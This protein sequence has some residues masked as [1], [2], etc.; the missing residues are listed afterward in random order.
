MPHLLATLAVTR[1]SMFRSFE[2]LGFE[3]VL[4]RPGKVHSAPLLSYTTHSAGIRKAGPGDLDAIVGLLRPLEDAGILVRR[5][6]E[7]LANLLQCCWTVAQRL[8][9]LMPDCLDFT[10]VER[11]TKVMGCALLLDLGK[12]E[13]GTHVAEVGRSLPANGRGCKCEWQ[14]MEMQMAEGANA[15]G[16]ERKCKWQRVQTHMAEDAYSNQTMAL[17]IAVVGHPLPAKVPPPHTLHRSG[18]AKGAFRTTRQ[19]AEI[20]TPF[21]LWHSQLGAFCVDPVFRGSGRGDSL[22][23]YVE[24]PHELPARWPSGSFRIYLDSLI[25]TSCHVPTALI[26]LSLAYRISSPIALI[27]AAC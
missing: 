26:A 24:Q 4:L 7:D 21:S 23:D 16:R 10:V 17:D 3:E 12:S 22:L 15:K 18:L 27:A 25:R 14:R 13:D 8:A 2:D 9:G 1:L 19:Q 5:S 11:E 20:T 6:R